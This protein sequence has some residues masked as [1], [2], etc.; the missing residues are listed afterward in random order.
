M[1][2]GPGLYNIGNSTYTNNK[3][4]IDSVAV[5]LAQAALTDILIPELVGGFSELAQIGFGYPGVSDSFTDFY[6]RFTAKPKFFTGSLPGTFPCLKQNDPP[7]LDGWH[8][9]TLIAVGL[10]TGCL[11]TALSAH[12]KERYSP[13]SRIPIDA[14]GE[15]CI[16]QHKRKSSIEQNKTLLVNS[17]PMKTAHFRISI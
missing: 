15:T 7:E 11:V 10:S 3:E 13:Q 17:R 8:H 5:E 12:R 14:D 2:A 9:R 16:S 1:L 6:N 4:L